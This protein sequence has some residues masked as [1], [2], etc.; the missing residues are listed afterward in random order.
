MRGDN[1][2]LND[3][4]DSQKKELSEQKKKISNLIWTKRE[5]TKAKEEIKNLNIQAADY[6]AQ[7]TKLTTENDS[8]MVS[9]DLLMGEKASL[10]AEVNAQMQANEEL[11]EA[12]AILASEK[13][14]LFHNFQ[15]YQKEWEELNE[16]H[17]QTTES[18]NQQMIEEGIGPTFVFDD[19]ISPEEIRQRDQLIGQLQD[20]N[21][22]LRV[23]NHGLEVANQG[24]QESNQK[25]EEIKQRLDIQNREL[26]K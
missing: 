25:L 24:L 19:S 15:V 1:K 23:E 8:L 13:A 22:Q 4:I 14:E 26:K 5:L 6:L 3:L 17:R 12:K 20:E 11:S 16:N 2:E 10:T 18:I 21:Q 9:N 7:I